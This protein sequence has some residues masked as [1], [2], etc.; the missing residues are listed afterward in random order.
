M[1]ELDK[2]QK[3]LIQL[4]LIFADDDNLSWYM[5]FIALWIA[6]NALCYAQ[7]AR[8]AVKP[9]SYL[10]SDKWLSTI[11]EEIPVTGSLRRQNGHVC[12]KIDSP[13]LQVS[14]K[15]R[16]AENIIYQCF[17]RYYNESYLDWLHDDPS[18][19][20]MLNAFVESIQKPNGCY[21]I[22]MLKSAD[23]SESIPLDTLRSSN[24][25]AAIIDRK[26]LRQI[27]DTLYQVRCNV[28][29]GEKTPGG[30]NDDGIVRTAHPL[31]RAFLQHILR[32]LE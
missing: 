24:I 31:L 10:K 26:N 28:F 23:Y 12:L 2:K 27:I 8:E 15:E 14:F 3:Q 32:S 6:F 7:F 13:K 30:P 9:I 16:Y 1:D 11:T 29:H 5:R 4:W 22:N 20:G 21:V 19:E 25:V 18:L 17:S